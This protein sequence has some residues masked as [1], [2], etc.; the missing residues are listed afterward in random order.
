VHV[1]QMAEVHQTKLDDLQCLCANCHRIEHRLLKLALED[2]ISF[3]P[4]R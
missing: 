2:K 3:P 4:N 1:E